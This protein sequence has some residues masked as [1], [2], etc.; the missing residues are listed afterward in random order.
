MDSRKWASSKLPQSFQINTDTVSYTLN[1][2]S[3]H[4]LYNLS[5]RN[6][7]KIRV[8]RSFPTRVS[9]LKIWHFWVIGTERNVCRW[10]FNRYSVLCSLQNSPLES[11]CVV[12]ALTENYS[13]SKPL[14]F[15]PKKSHTLSC[16]TVVL[17]H[18]CVVTLE[19]WHCCVVTL[20]SQ[21]SDMYMHSDLLGVF[22]KPRSQR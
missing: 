10:T 12:V 13:T 16:D 11:S 14:K 1:G 3:H 9:Q 18:C 20:L 8:Y 21:M 15:S 6:Y 17:W 5:F 4:I 22:K 7:R 2:Y 19:L